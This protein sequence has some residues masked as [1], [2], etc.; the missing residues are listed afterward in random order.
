MICIC[1]TQAWYCSLDWTEFRDNWRVEM[2]SWKLVKQQ[3]QQLEQRH[4]QFYNRNSNFAGIWLCLLT[5]F[6]YVML[7][8]FFLNTLKGVP[9]VPKAFSRSYYTPFMFL[10]FAQFFKFYVGLRPTTLLVKRSAREPLVPRVLSGRYPENTAI[11]L[12]LGE[13]R[14]FLTPTTV[15]KTA[16]N[17]PLSWNQ[18][19]NL[20]SLMG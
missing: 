10:I 7:R 8:L 13:S 17:L 11:W 19:E 9:W 5:L 12:V 1:N 16:R 6:I 14:I 4:V 20:W 18:I 15:K 3:Q 2:N